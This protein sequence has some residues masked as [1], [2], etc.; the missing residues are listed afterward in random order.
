MQHLAPIAAGFVLWGLV[1]LIPLALGLILR[2]AA[3]GRVGFFFCLA[4]GFLMGIVGPIA[5]AIGFSIGI[6]ASWYR[7]RSRT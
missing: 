3:L 2:Q 6:T 7:S 1:G 4:A 5:V